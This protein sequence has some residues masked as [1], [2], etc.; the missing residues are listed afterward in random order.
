MIA[1]DVTA[2]I[3]T[4]FNNLV[5]AYR[6]IAEATILEI[7]PYSNDTYFFDGDAEV[8]AVRMADVHIAE[9]YGRPMNQILRATF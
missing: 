3:I 9:T 7:R 5:T 8:A 6:P 2:T 4:E 1:I